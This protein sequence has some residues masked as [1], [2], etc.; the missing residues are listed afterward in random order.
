MTTA[1]RLLRHIVQLETRHEVKQFMQ[2]NYVRHLHGRNPGVYYGCS[3]YGDEVLC[4]S[5]T[6][7]DLFK[8]YARAYEKGLHVK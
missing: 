8:I 6:A 2:V 4:P 3:I 5:L 7:L 1:S